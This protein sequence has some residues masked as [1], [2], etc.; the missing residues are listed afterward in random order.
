[1]S[2]NDEATFAVAAH[3]QGNQWRMRQLPESATDS[4]DELLMQ[5][6]SD[7]T[8]GAVVGLVCIDDDWC[9]VVRPVPGGVRLLLS[10]VT[11][12]L[13]YDLAHDMLDELDVDTPSEEEAEESD[14]P[15]PEGDFDVLE[16]LGAGEQILSVIFD[17]EYLYASEQILRVAEE[18]GFAEDLAELV[19]LELDF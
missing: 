19:G 14:E 4:L 10:D 3:G 8:E 6:R 18:L 17:D 9:A 12:S 15:W 16:D 5:L 1:M 13:D 2:D 11:A 7:R